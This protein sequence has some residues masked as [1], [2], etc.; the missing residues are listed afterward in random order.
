MTR[1]G[2]EQTLAINTGTATAPT[3]SVV[4]VA[5]DASIDDDSDE[6]SV[7]RRSAEDRKQAAR[8]LVSRGIA[9]AI[10]AP[11][12][13]A[14]S[15]PP[16]RLLAA[17]RSRDG[18]VDVCAFDSATVAGGVVT[19]GRGIRFAALVKHTDDQPLGGDRWLANFELKPGRRPSSWIAAAL[20]AIDFNYVRSLLAPVELLTEGGVALL[21]EADVPLLTEG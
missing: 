1:N 15:T 7:G 20:P 5:G 3:W 12:T 8:S 4:D 16:A 19:E 9:F 6:V 17:S 14:G 10:E 18:I 2:Y 13:A 21:T 11:T